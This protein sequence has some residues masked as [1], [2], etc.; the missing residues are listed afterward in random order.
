MTVTTAS[1]CDPTSSWL[2][3]WPMRAK[4]DEAVKA[5]G[6]HPDNPGKTGKAVGLHAI[7]ALYRIEREGKDVSPEERYTVRQQKAKPLLDTLRAW[8]D[9][10]LPRRAHV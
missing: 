2:A 9:T 3:A 4:F 1:V 10:A 7:Q 6:A 8:L 5:Q